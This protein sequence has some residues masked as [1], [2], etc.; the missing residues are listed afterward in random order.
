MEEGRLREKEGKPLWIETSAFPELQ[1]TPLG[2]QPYPYILNNSAPIFI[3]LISLMCSC[4]RISSPYQINSFKIITIHHTLCN[5]T[6]STTCIWLSYI[7][8]HL[9]FGFRLWTS[10]GLGLYR[11][12]V[13]AVMKRIDWL[14]SHSDHWLYLCRPRL[15]LKEIFDKIHSLFSGKLS[16]L[17]GASRVCHPNPQALTLIQHTN[18]QRNLWWETLLPKLHGKKRLVP[19]L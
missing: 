4:F 3:L 14:Q 7:F 16:S 18:W 17:V 8:L 9:Y 19:S 11:G 12:F 1:V 6:S 15:K 10:V 13:I 5:F 2:H